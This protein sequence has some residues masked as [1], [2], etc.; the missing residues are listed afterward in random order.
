VVPASLAFTQAASPFASN[1][2]A[3]QKLALWADLLEE[4]LAGALLA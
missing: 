2:S 4:V 3:M 1:R